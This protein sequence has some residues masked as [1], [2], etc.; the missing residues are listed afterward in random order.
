MSFRRDRSILLPSSVRLNRLQAR[1]RPDLLRLFCHG[2]AILSFALVAFGLSVGVWAGYLIESGN[3]HTVI[4]GQLYRSAE[5]SRHGFEQ[6]IIR[7]HIRT[8]IN[9]RGAAPGHPW[10][11]DEIAA[12]RAAGAHHIDFRMSATHLPNS[13]EL[14]EIETM[15]EHTE[16]PVLVHCQGGADRSGLVAALYE[17]WIA[18]LPPADAGAQL[19]FRF[20]HFP[21]LGSRTAA[22][23]EAWQ[24]V[25]ANGS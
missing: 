21:W 14:Q 22:M 2:G 15:L 12:T 1:F 18:H 8:V 19:S 17:L 6:A 20:G 25:I 24:N 9:L 23:D 10:Y 11:E 3:F 5:L 7:F 13:A 16:S 4:P